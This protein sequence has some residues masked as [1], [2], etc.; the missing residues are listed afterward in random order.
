MHMRAAKR[1]RNIIVRE[2]TAVQRDKMQTSELKLPIGAGS[3][4]RLKVT[5]AS[6]IS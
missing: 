2:A 4:H 1:E 6:Q 3:S 5:S